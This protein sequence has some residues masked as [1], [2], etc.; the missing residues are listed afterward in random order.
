M[1]ATAFLAAALALHPAPAAKAASL[2][3]F[4][5]PSGN[6]NCIGGPAGYGQPAFVECLVLKHTWPA[7]ITPRKPA[8]CDL[9]SAHC[10]R[11]P[12]GRWRC[13]SGSRP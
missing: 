9:D 5:S 1:L 6:I 13:W 11:S 8:N 12:P 10:P 4:E 3:H 2:V 7:S